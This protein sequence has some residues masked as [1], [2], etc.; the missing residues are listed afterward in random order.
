MNQIGNK[1][2]FGRVNM[3][4]LEV[5][6]VNIQYESIMCNGKVRRNKTKAFLS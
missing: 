1:M 5:D 6:K 2:I 4:L 3:C